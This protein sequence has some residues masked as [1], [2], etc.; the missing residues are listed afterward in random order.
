VLLQRIRKVR[1]PSHLASDMEY[2]SACVTIV[3]RVMQ[4]ML[5]EKVTGTPAA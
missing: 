1:T 5:E 3:M 2:W 4:E